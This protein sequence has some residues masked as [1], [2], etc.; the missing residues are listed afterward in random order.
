MTKVLIVD[1]YDSFTFNLVQELG[2]LGAEPLVFRN[3]AL[4]VDQAMALDV[5]AVVV[6]PGPC[7][8][9]SAGISIELI[10]RCAGVRP[11]LGVCLGHQAIGAAFGARV[12]RNVRVV[13]GKAS[14]VRHRRA[15]VF[16]QLPSPFQAGRYHSLVL[17]RET[18]PSC[19]EVTAWTDEGEVMGVR[20]ARFD[21]EGVQFHP[22]SVLTPAGRVLLS[23]WLTRV[24]RR[25]S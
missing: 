1:N 20:H 5:A 6:S 7:A 4:T 14:P 17:E 8:P 16:R 21:V 25:T 19:L 18:L 9:E 22:E 10:R 3:D 12:V 11:L 13:H 15:G 2:A 23:T 24:S